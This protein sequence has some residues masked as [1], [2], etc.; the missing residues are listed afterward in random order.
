MAKGTKVQSVD[1]SDDSES[2]DDEEYSKEDLMEM[3]QE[4]H[5]LMNKRG[6]FKELR[7]R[8]KFLEQ[9][10]DELN[11]THERLKEAHEKAHSSLLAQEKKEPIATSNL[12]ATCDILNEEFYTPILLLPLTPHVAHP[13]LLHL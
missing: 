8:N 2:D 5:S 7:K 9:S 11:A 1:E 3:V 10:F 12:G 13:L 6:E 4:A